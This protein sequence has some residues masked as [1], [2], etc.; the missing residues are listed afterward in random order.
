MSEFFQEAY[1][2]ARD[3]YT[4]EHWLALTPQQ[5]TESIYR[6]MRQM[7]AEATAPLSLGEAGAGGESGDEAVGGAESGL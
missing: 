1:R 2:R 6:E 7:D 3:R 4:R 5:I